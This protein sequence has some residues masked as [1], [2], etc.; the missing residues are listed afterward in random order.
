MSQKDLSYGDALKK[1]LSSVRL[2]GVESVPVSECCTRVLAESIHAPFDSP[3]FDNS[4]VDGYAVRSS[5]LVDDLPR[6]LRLVGSSRAG[7]PW[8]SE[9]RSGETVQILTGAMM[10]RGCDA[11]VMQEDVSVQGSSVSIKDPVTNGQFVRY[12]GEEYRAGALLTHRGTMCSPAVVGV[13]ASIGRTAASVFR[14]PRVWILSTGDELVLPSRPLSTG[15][16][17][18]SNGLALQAACSTLAEVHQ[19]VH[20][21]DE[22]DATTQAVADALGDADILISSGGISVGS[23]DFVKQAFSANGV[24]EVFWGVAIRP[25][26]PLWFGVAGEKLVFGL[27]GNPVAALVCFHQ[28]VRPAFRAMT[29]LEP[30]RVVHAELTEALDKRTP[31]LEFVRGRLVEGRVTPIEARGS[32]MLGGLA[33]A[34]CLIH[35][36]AE[37]SR[38]EAGER[39]QVTPLRW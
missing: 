22:P 21:A 27:P 1:V 18:A 36:P 16:V 37:Q 29:G 34:D 20:V 12:Q 19:P 39:V 8:E 28:F 26:H 11:V 25:G 10:P 35:F 17:Y 13:L 5:D 14:K 33:S 2:I 6:T 9:V 15:Q 24:R 23:H 31:R 3:A 32:H 38:L 4:S 30:E 7:H